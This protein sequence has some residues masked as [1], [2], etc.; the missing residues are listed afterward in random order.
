[1]TLFFKLDFLEPTHKVAK[2]FCHPKAGHNP[3]VEFIQHS[4]HSPGRDG[5]SDHVQEAS[6]TARECRADEDSRVGRFPPRLRPERSCCCYDSAGTHL[7]DG[8]DNLRLRL[9]AVC[10]PMIHLDNNG[11]PIPQNAVR[12]I[13]S[14]RRGSPRPLTSRPRRCSHR[15]PLP[16]WQFA[17]PASH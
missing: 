6:L 14:G 16:L 7:H 1:M 12:E 15:S 5:M 17:S 8:G 11:N 9:A 10:E 3:P 13:R 2:Q 4:A